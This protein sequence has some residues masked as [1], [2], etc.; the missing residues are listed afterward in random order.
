MPMP[1]APGAVDKIQE[2]IINTT[3]AGEARTAAAEAL[4]PWQWRPYRLELERARADADRLWARLAR[5]ES[6]CVPG[7]ILA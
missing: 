5:L 6:H 1:A 4:A 2:P 3:I 7:P